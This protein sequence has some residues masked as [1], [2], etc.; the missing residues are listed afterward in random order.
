MKSRITL[1]AA[2][3]ALAALGARDAAADVDARCYNEWNAALVTLQVGEKC[4]F[5]DG[6]GAEKVRKAQEERMQCALA[7]ATAAERAEMTGKTA[8]AARKDSVAQVAAMQ[9]GSVRAAFDAQ[10][11]ALAK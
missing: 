1:A 11:K 2:A 5:L 10:V 7:K 6:A 9:C 4:K 8:P 3:C